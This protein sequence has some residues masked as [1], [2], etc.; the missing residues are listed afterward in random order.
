MKRN[1]YI[2][3]ITETIFVNV[4]KLLAATEKLKPGPNE[5]EDSESQTGG[6]GHTTTPGTGG[7]DTSG[8]WHGAKTN[9]WGSWDD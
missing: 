7:D 3:P 6:T 5:T 2:K 1:K 9:P 4:E 8:G